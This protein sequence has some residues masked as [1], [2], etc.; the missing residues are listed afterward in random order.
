M[1]VHLSSGKY[2]ILASDVAFLFGPFEDLTIA[3]NEN[4]AELIRI[5]LKFSE[6]TSGER[7]V[8]TEVLDDSLII[9]CVN[10][11]G[12]ETGLKSPAYIADIDGKAVYFMFASTSR[13]SKDGM[14]RSVKY[15]VF[16]EK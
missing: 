5:V 7:D 12:M 4:D 2:D 16:R 11:N 10:F 3:I 13:G 15:T 14:S 1:K 6:N 9:N 8:V